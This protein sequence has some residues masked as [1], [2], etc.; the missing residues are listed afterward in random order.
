[1]LAD[2]FTAEPPPTVVP[3]N[4]MVVTLDVQKMPPFS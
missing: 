2:Q 1:M 3:V 4:K